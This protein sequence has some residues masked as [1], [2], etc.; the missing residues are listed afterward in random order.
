MFEYIDIEG[1]WAE[2]TIRRLSYVGVGF[3]GG[4]FKP[5]SEIVT[6]EF[7]ELLTNTRIYNH[8]EGFTLPDGTITRADAVKYIIYALGYGKIAS[9]ENVFIS[10]FADGTILKPEDV[11][12]IAIARAFGIIEGDGNTFRP[13]ELITRAEVYTMV[14]NIIEKQLIY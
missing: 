6:E 1:H 10:N 12:H 3:D 13:Y 7:Y 14:E 9:L 11:G 2:D 8:T 4:E 5:D